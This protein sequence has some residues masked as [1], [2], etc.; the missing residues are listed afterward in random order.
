M[1][2][3]ILAG[4]S[5]NRLKHSFNGSCCKPL[6]KIKEK[7]LIEFS[8]ENLI[9]LQIKEVWIV[10]GSESD[11]IQAEIGSDYKG[12]NISYV[13]QNET[14]GLIGALSLA[15]KKVK[16]EDIL[17]QLADEIFTGFNTKTIKQHINKF[18]YDFYCGF[19]YE[20]DDKK[21]KANYSIDVDEYFNIIK[22]TEKPEAVINNLK[23]TG[24]CIF[25]SRS[26]NLLK[27]T[28]NSK[29]V[30]DL[31]DFINL[32]L[33]KNYCGLAVCIAEKEFNINTFEDLKEAIDYLS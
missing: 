30:Q 24:F 27:T 7:A 15:L 11:L 9:D 20:N 14:D 23:G 32:L 17:L 21:I 19:T 10:V 28:N 29:S 8:L 1:V 12:L 33:L 3:M 13:K 16:D 26:L 6:V 4:G 2:G 5:G 22:C 18:K 25:N 31:C